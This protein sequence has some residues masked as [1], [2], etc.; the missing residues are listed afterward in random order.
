MVGSYF[1][2][3]VLCATSSI[4]TSIEAL[5]WLNNKAGDVTTDASLGRFNNGKPADG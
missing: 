2:T 5:E 4:L 3:S 1:L